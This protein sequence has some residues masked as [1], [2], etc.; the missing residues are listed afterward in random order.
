MMTLDMVPGSTK[1]AL[2][3]YDMS[4]LAIN[5]SDLLSSPEIAPKPRARRTTK[6]TTP[7]EKKATTARQHFILLDI[8]VYSLT[9]DYNKLLIETN[10]GETYFITRRS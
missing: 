9:V 6:K 1:S 2:N 7:P 10:Y 4:A 8:S 5:P 3:F